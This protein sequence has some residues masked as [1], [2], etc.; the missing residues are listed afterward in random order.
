MPTCEKHPNPLIFNDNIR[1]SVTH[2]LDTPRPLCR[3]A[4]QNKI[5]ESPGETA[6][7]MEHY[8][9]RCR[10]YTD[11]VKLPSCS[12]GWHHRER[13]PLR[14]EIRAGRLAGEPSSPRG[15]FLRHARSGCPQRYG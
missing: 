7:R 10:S 3:S 5:D 4:S 13:A 12:V 11:Y 15:K 2:G 8:P 1:V 6:M 9:W 14:A